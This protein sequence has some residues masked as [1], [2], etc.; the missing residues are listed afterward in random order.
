MPATNA[1][2]TGTLSGEE[3]QALRDAAE[4]ADK[5]ATVMT[6]AVGMLEELRDALRRIAAQREAA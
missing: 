4:M 3:S 2:T 5:A 1:S 6:G